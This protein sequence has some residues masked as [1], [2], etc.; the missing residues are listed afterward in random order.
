MSTN[1]DVLR[2]LTRKSATVRGRAITLT[3]PGSVTQNFFARGEEQE[4]TGYEN[5]AVDDPILAPPALEFDSFD[6]IPRRRGSWFA[7]AVS[8]L[9]VAAIGFV[10]WRSFHF[11]SRPG[12]SVA[13]ASRAMVQSPPPA[14]PAPVAQSMTVAPE[15]TTQSAPVAQPA[16][17]AQSAPTTE[18]APVA[19]PAPVT[20]PAPVVEPPPVTKPEPVVEPLPNPKPAPATKHAPV[21]HDPGK[22][23]TDDEPVQMRKH[24]PLHGYVWSPDKHTLVPAEPVIEDLPSEAPRSQSLEGTPAKEPQPAPDPT[25]PAP[26][27]PSPSS[28]PVPNQAPIIE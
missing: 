9:V 10:T 23:D 27:Q 2:P 3:K 13:A 22:S 28:S 15:P 14:A 26:F 20:R 16:P 25:S 1:T 6:K 11:L 7:V 12:S 8:T 17:V 5:L 18:A 24:P 21:A 19:P 4:A